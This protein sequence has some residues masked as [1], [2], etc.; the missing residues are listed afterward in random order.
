M[1]SQTRVVCVV[2]P[3]KK[4]LDITVGLK[5]QGQEIISQLSELLS[6]KELHLFGLYNDH[7][8][9]DLE[10]KLRTYFSKAWKHKSSQV[11][12]KERIVLHLRVQYFVGNGR[13]IQE[14]KVLGLYYAD[15]KNRVLTSQCYDQ[16]G[17]YFQ[18]IAYA[19]QADLGDWTEGKEHYFSPCDYF[20]P[21]ILAKRGSD[22]VVQHTPVL[23]KE[24]LGMCVHDAVLL[25]IQE[26]S[27][28]NDIPINFYSMSKS[29]K[30]QT[31][32][33]FLGLALNGLHIYEMVRGRQQLLFELVW[34]SIDRITFQGRKFEI[35]S[36]TLPGS[37]LVLYTRSFLHSQNLLKHMSNT[38]CFLLNNKPQVTAGRRHYREVCI[39]DRTYL[40][41]E[42]SEEKL[43]PLISHLAKLRQLQERSAVPILYTDEVELCVDEPEEMLVDDPDEVI[44]LIKEVSVDEPLTAAS[45]W[46]DITTEMKQVL[47][48]RTCSLSLDQCREFVDHPLSASVNFPEK[49]LSLH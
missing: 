26:A 2:L 48:W 24:L 13:L 28:I 21:W 16:E 40:D 34:S 23:H 9:L 29:K 14:E 32:S 46:I 20:P 1:T 15:L 38:H 36:E 6:I 7:L 8:F 42:D 31:A 49:I 10:D 5:S 44:K 11:K 19:L 39:S 17:L 3:N 27:R 30:D 35:K 47:S 18:L 25:F 12:P 43:P 22:Y 41:T 37:K 4:Q 45:H 33:V